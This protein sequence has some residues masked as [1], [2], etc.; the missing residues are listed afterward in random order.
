MLVLG[1]ID[2]RAFLHSGIRRQGRTYELAH[3]FRA[4]DITLRY[5]DHQV[6]RRTPVALA[7]RAIRVFSLSGNE[8]VVAEPMGSRRVIRKIEISVSGLAWTSICARTDPRVDP[9][10]RHHF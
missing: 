2:G 5:L 7:R 8:R 1:P 3:L 4:C 6:V 9:K 10:Q